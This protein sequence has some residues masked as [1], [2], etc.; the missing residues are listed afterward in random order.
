MLIHEIFNTPDTYVKYQGWT[1]QMAKIVSW[2]V[3][4]APEAAGEIFSRTNPRLAVGFHSMVV[5]GTTQSI[6]DAVRTRYDGPVLISQ[7]FTVV[8]ITPEQIVTLMARFEPAPFLTPPDEDY[9][10]SKGGSQSKTMH[11]LPDWLDD[12]II[13]IDFIEEFRKE[14]KEKGIGQAGGVIRDPTIAME[15]AGSS[16]AQSKGP[17]SSSRQAQGADTLCWRPQR[18]GRRRH[19]N[20]GW[21]RTR[22]L[23]T[24]VRRSPARRSRS[25]KGRATWSMPRHRGGRALGL[26]RVRRAVIHSGRRAHGSWSLALPVRG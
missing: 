21:I 20:L 17:V 5:S 18:R 1:E 6:L 23:P 10:K 13:K 3:H 7:D 22:V 12:S 11:L 4:T 8:N 2:T 24:T 19:R 9:V 14:L 25:P 15:G 26:D 16:G